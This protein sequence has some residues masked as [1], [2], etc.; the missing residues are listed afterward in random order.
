MFDAVLREQERELRYGAGLALALLAHAAAFALAAAF[1]PS[2][3]RSERLQGQFPVL[4]ESV[5]LEPPPPPP[6]P[7]PA[8]PVAA[9]SAPSRAIVR[10]T[11]KP[12]EP[13]KVCPADKPVGTYPYCC[14]KTY[15]YRDKACRCPK[16]KVV[17]NGLCQVPPKQEPQQKPQQPQQPPKEAKPCPP[18]TYG[19]PPICIP[20]KEKKQK[21]KKPWPFLA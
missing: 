12:V 6:P 15:E 8:G 13:K 17:I 16:G 18:G 21:P 5:S 2:A 7:P 14:P 20:Q 1:L 10:P 9:E 19:I 3:S 11:P 4:L